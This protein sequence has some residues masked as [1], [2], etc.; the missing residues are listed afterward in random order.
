MQPDETGDELVW[1]STQEAIASSKTY[2]QALQ[3]LA[4]QAM[5]QAAY[6]FENTADTGQSNPYEIVWRDWD[7]YNEAEGLTFKTRHWLSFREEIQLRLHRWQM[8]V[9][10]LFSSLLLGVFGLA[11]IVIGGAFIVQ[12][13]QDQYFEWYLFEVCLFISVVL[14]GLYKLAHA[15]IW[16]GQPESTVWVGQ[17]VFAILKVRKLN[18]KNLH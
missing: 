9:L 14:V 7:K 10:N 4:H 8:Q 17:R 16:L 18:P 13:I 2:E 5:H 6:D 15:S 1:L 11:L 3:I 12:L